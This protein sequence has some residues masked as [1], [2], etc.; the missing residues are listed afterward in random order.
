MCADGLWKEG[1]RH[2]NRKRSIAA[3]GL[4]SYL[5]HL[6]RDEPE[7]RTQ[8]L[9]KPAETGRGRLVGGLNRM[10]ITRVVWEWLLDDTWGETDQTIDS[11]KHRIYRCLAGGAT[12]ETTVAWILEAFDMSKE[13]RD[14]AW[15]LFYSAKARASLNRIPTELRG[16]DPVDWTDLR[17]LRARAETISAHEH[18]VVGADRRPRSH[19]TLQIVRAL[20]DGV[21]RY[22]YLWDSDSAALEVVHGG[23]I[24]EV[25]QVATSPYCAAFIRFD[26]TLHAGDTHSME[27]VLAYDHAE[28]P[29]PE[30]QRG[31]LGGRSANIGL[32]LSFH[33]A[34]V[35]RR[36][37][38][39]EWPDIQSPPTVL[40][41]VELDADSSAHRFYEQLRDRIV[42]F[43]W[44]W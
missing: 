15:A 13:H 8:W 6:L 19:R 28:A 10:A 3:T 14:Q 16:S 32:R 38:L 35:P 11:L 43:T 7:Y 12:H 30:F 21:E 9:R 18:H 25:H 41:E 2:V 4:S 20:E 31:V 44:E 40:D 34:A 5:V 42:G 22:P 23:T 39:A 37:H 36:V 33:P 29:P 17:P 1:E 24:E 26:R 27:L